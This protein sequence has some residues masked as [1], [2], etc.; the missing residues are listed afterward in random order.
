MS[1][2]L[3]EVLIHIYIYIY[4]I[5]YLTTLSQRLLNQILHKDAQVPNSK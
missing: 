3:L 2:D 5:T 4:N 1:M